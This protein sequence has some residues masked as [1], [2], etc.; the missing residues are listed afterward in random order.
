MQELFH[1]MK[2]IGAVVTMNTECLYV[3]IVMTVRKRVLKVIE[4]THTHILI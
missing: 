4:A 1:H 2:S 3:F